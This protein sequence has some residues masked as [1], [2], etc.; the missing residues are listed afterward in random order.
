VGIGVVLL[1]AFSLGAALMATTRAVTA[2]S[3]ER[4]ASDLDA[5]RFAFYRLV[6]DRAEFAGAQAALVTALPVFRAYMTDSRLA[7]DAE[8]LEAMTDGYRRQLKATFAIVTDRDGTWIAQ[9]GWPAHSS[10]QPVGRTISQAVSGRSARDMVVVQDQLFLVVSEPARFADELL[11]TLTAGYVLDDAVAERLAAVTHCDVNLGAVDRSAGPEG[12]IEHLFA[13]SLPLHDRGSLTTLV[14]AKNWSREGVANSVQRLGSSSYVIGS[15]PLSFGGDFSSGRLLL[16]QN[17]QPAQLFI[18]EVQSR[19]LAA[20]SFIF[21]VA[22]VGSLTFSRRMSRPLQDLANAAEDIASGN[23]NRQVPIRGG[24]EAT[25]MAQAFNEM[26]TSLRHWFEEARKRND[27]LRQAQKMEAIGR[28]AGGV[29]HDFNNLLTVIKGYGELLVESFDAV[30]RRRGD[31]VEILK[32]AER[33]S[34]LTRQLLAFSRRNT[35]A[36]RV[37]SLEQVVLGTEQMLR[38]LIGEDVALRTSAAPGLK[39]VLVDPGQIEQVLLN[40]VVNA[41]DAMPRGGTLTIDITNVEFEEGDRS[42]HPKL[43]P[44][45][46]V[47]LSVVD[48]GSGMS[49]ETAARIFEPFFTTKGEGVGT[50]LGLSMVYGVV[51]RAGGAIEV[52]SELG[53]GTAFHLYLPASAAVPASD[54]PA[55]REEVPVI[56]AVGCETVLLVEDETHVSALIAAALRKSG[57]TVL[58]AMNGEQAIEMARTHG[59]PIHLLLTDVVMPGMNGRELADHIKRVRDETHVLYMSGYS[60]DAILRHGVQTNIAHFIQKPFSMDRLTTKIREALETESPADEGRT[61]PVEGGYGAH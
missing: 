23:W 20:G 47:R 6:D 35:V 54:L 61:G 11:G 7:K 57:Y 44:G 45:P 26:T 30:D 9:P 25:M 16:L 18:D 33:A 15:F 40:L 36:P 2:R 22:L 21:I 43:K 4:A 37:V 19:L 8:T 1:V 59:T 27:E 51:D 34:S 50:G 3:L 60:D 12:R 32:A 39:S 10:P 24:T 5:A 49:A 41:R 13:S 17:W 31:A 29:A 52:D 28:L 42:R 48:T 58:Q 55:A 56:P 38:R 53:R 14:G 46:H